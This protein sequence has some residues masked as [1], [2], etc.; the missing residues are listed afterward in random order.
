MTSVRLIKAKKKLKASNL[1]DFN[2][3]GS[4]ER[5]MCN[6]DEAFH[7]IGKTH[8]SQSSVPPRHKYRSRCFSRFMD[9]FSFL[10]APCSANSNIDCG[11]QLILGSHEKEGFLRIPFAFRS[12]GLINLLMSFSLFLCSSIFCATFLPSLRFSLHVS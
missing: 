2:I 9:C 6:S 7:W 8:A 1:R 4:N 5:T 11:K 3:D 12:S 10:L